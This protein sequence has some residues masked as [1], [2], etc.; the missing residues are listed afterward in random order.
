MRIAKVAAVAA[1]SLVVVNTAANVV[2][3]TKRSG[4]S[5]RTV[6]RITAR[7]VTTPA[8]VTYRKSVT[9]TA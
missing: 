1:T 3:R 2:I 5:I 7:D 8:L 4:T 6:R 9:A